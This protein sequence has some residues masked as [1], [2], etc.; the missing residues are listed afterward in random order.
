MA[1]GDSEIVQ[2]LISSIKEMR[3]EAEWR[4]H[5]AAMQEMTMKAIQEMKESQAKREEL[6]FAKLE[7]VKC[8]LDSKVSEVNELITRL[9]IRVAGWSAIYSTAATILMYFIMRYV[10]KAA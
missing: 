5:T 3:E 6:L 8:K 2:A 7:E 9:R 10:F 1:P 4:G